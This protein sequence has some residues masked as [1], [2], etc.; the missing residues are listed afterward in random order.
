MMLQEVYI[1]DN[2]S[3]NYLAIL[4]A[5]VVFY[6]LGLLWYS[7]AMFGNCCVKHDDWRENEFK[8][9][10]LVWA[11][12]GEFII[13][14]IIAN[15]L[16]IFVVLFNLGLSGAIILALLIWI[17]FV[18]TTHFSAVLWGRKTFGH[19]CI[20]V[21]FLLIGFILMGAILGW[22]NQIG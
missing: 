8:K 9:V 14:F 16:A 5:A 21:G 11:Y 4:V 18:A 10:P 7:P 3:I 19:Y 22:F 15:A 6:L 2:V 20:H 1:T 12:I 17:G 13:S